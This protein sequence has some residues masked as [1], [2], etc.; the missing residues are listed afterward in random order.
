MK[1]KDAIK[2]I[3]AKKK[4]RVELAKSQFSLEDLKLKAQEASACRPFI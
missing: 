1:A 3:I 2:E 4:E